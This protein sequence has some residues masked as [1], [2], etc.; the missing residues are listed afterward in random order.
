MTHTRWLLGKVHA[1]PN[2]AT[3]LVLSVSKV[4]VRRAISGTRSQLL[5]ALGSKIRAHG[6]AEPAGNK[7]TQIQLNSQN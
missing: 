7:I 1:A 6:G 3:P 2:I 5:A 4:V